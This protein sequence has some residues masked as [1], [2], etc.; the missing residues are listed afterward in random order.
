MPINYLRGASWR[1]EIVIADE[2]QNFTFKELTTL[3]TRLGEGDKLLICGDPMQK[4]HQW[5]QRICGHVL[6]FQ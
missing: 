3:M 6:T 2:S 1:N 4:R 5:P